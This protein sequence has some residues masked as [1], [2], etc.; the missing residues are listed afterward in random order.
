MNLDRFYD[1]NPN[2]AV[3]G[4][5]APS[6]ARK[7]LAP[8]V[9]DAGQSHDRPQREPAQ[10]SAFRLPERRSRSRSGRRE[11]LSTT[12]TRSGS[13]PF[14]IG[15]SRVSD[16]FGHQMQFADTLSWSRGRHTSRFGGSLMHHTSGGTGSE[17]GPALLGTFTFL[18]HDDGAVRSAD[19]GR[20][21]AVL[22][23]RSASASPATS[24]SSGCR[25]RS[26]RTA[27]ACATTSRSTLGLRYDRQTLTDATKNFAPRVGFG[28]HPGGDSRLV[29]SRRLRRCTTRRSAPTRSPAS[30]ERA[31]RHRHL[32][33]DAGAARL[34]D[35]PDGLV[36]ARCTSI[37][38]RCRCRSS[39]RANIT[40]RAGRRDVL[41]DAVRD[42]T[43]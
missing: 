30:S 38:R 27:S 14:T 36:P 26:C 5:N 31:G 8:V 19:A 33:G 24:S 17:P 43:G 39:R 32:H 18:Q 13:V 21:A 25:S 37:P 7:L 6:V 3:V 9:D 40:I 29:D 41:P 22:R 16:L 20:R 23:S 35:L 34:S 2:D 28:W 10:R 42:A 11:T 1:T 15:E 12:Y 4:T